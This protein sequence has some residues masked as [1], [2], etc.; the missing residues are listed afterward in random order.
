VSL[1]DDISAAYADLGTVFGRTITYRRGA[2]SI[3]LTS[4]RAVQIGG[5]NGQASDGLYVQSY[6]AEE[7]FLASD[8]TLGTPLRGDTIEEVIGGETRIY[9]VVPYDGRVCHR[10]TD[11][12]RLG[13]GVATVETSR[14]GS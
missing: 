12:Q 4:R 2:E 1:S 14:S 8:F 10:Y 6:T 5:I 9:N 11:T 7:R 13:M 3:D